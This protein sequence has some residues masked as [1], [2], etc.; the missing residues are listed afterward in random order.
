MVIAIS[1][2]IGSGKSTLSKELSN[3]YN[4][5]ILVEEFSDND[6]VF[7]TFLKW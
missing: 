4:N 7:N 2:M 5:S 3:I 6:E 1:G